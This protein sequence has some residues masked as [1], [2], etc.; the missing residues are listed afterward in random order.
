MSITN[1]AIR[2][3]V[4][5]LWKNPHADGPAIFSTRER[6]DRTI[7]GFSGRGA[8]AGAKVVEIVGLNTPGREMCDG[9]LV[10]YV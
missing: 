4:G 5:R 1:Y 2:L 3:K 7:A 9:Y 6:A 10:R 8:L